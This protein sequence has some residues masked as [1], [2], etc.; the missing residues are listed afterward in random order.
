MFDRL[1]STARSAVTAA[2]DEARRVDSPQ[3]GSEHLLVALRAQGTKV[4]TDAGYDLAAMRHTLATMNRAAGQE[5]RDEMALA[6]IGIELGA[7]RDAV[8][9]SF[10]PTAWSRSRAHRA[11]SWLGRPARSSLPFSDEAR[12][13]FAEAVREAATTR[14]HRIG[15]EQLLLGITRS[16]HSLTRLLVEGQMP[17]DQ[18]RQR[19]RQSLHEAT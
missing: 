17:V 12:K 2:A 8:T 7:V 6:A 14:D 18:L 11:R 15:P 19:T 10:G 13:A 5:A 16:P 4:L 1:T 9:R 3:I